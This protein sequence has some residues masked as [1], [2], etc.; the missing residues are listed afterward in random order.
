M[1]SLPDSSWR[2]VWCVMPRRGI[3]PH[4][5]GFQQRKE[6]KGLFQWVA[7][8]PGNRDHFCL[9]VYPGSLTAGLREAQ[10]RT[11]PSTRWRERAGLPQGWCRTRGGPRLPAPLLDHLGTWA[12]DLPCCPLSPLQLTQPGR[13]RELLTERDTVGIPALHQRVDR[14]PSE[15]GSLPVLTWPLIIHSFIHYPKAPA[16]PR[17]L[18]GVV[19][20]T[21]TPQ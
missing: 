11:Q 4:L 20:V 21:G 7:C 3:L 12:H 6:Q 2:E 8:V 17:L 19:L 10:T 5:P 16:G 14:T 15:T 13:Q 18:P 9:Y 1:E